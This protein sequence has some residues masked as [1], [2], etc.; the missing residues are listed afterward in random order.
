MLN[1]V[2]DKKERE[3]LVSLL[4]QQMAVESECISLYSETSKEV[5]SSSV[6]HLFHMIQLDSIKHMDVCQLIIDVLQGEDVLKKEKEE[7]INGLQRH[8]DLEKD[9]LNTA[10]KIEHKYLIRNT[11]G[12]KEL[13]KKWKNDEK[14]HHNALRK[15]ANKT[16]FATFGDLVTSFKSPEQL[17]ERYVGYK[18]ALK[19]GNEKP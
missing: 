17:E 10:K 6:K 2:V 5:V 14:E 18:R 13:V 8:L 4:R 11:E 15:L 16:F 7:I 9:S 3:E 19:T 12:L 1:D